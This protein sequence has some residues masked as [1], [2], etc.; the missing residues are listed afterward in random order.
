[1]AHYDSIE[2]FAEARGLKVEKRPNPRTVKPKPSSGSSG[3]SKKSERKSY[4]DESGVIRYEGTDR[5]KES[6]YKKAKS[7]GQKG[8]SGK[9]T[10]RGGSGSGATKEKQPKDKIKVERTSE[11]KKAIQKAKKTGE[12]QL[13]RQGGTVYTIKPDGSFEVRGPSSAAREYVRKQRL[14][15]KIRTG[16]EIVAGDIIP[17]GGTVFQ[18]DS[19][20][21]VKGI[22]EY[23]EQ[24]QEAD[25]P[26]SVPL[27]QENKFLSQREK[28]KNKE[29]SGTISKWEPSIF[30]KAKTEA[31]KAADIRT[32]EQLE[33]AKQGSK[34]AFKTFFDDSYRMQQY[35]LTRQ[36]SKGNIALILGI[37]AGIQ[38]VKF[39]SAAKI[40]GPAIG[41][42]GGF[43]SKVIKLQK[44]GP[45]TKAAGVGI[46]K[47]LQI[48]SSKPV[49]GGVI[50]LR[51][52]ESGVSEFYRSGDI[53]K[54]VL[55]GGLRFTSDAAAY[56]GF[57]MNF[58]KPFTSGQKYGQKKAMQMGITKT[59]IYGKKFKN[60]GTNLIDK[61]PY[62][63]PS[64]KYP[65]TDR[66]IQML[67]GKV[68]KRVAQES[69]TILYKKIN[70]LNLRE[71]EALLSPRS[72]KPKF[73]DISKLRL[74]ATEPNQQKL[75]YDIGMK[76][77]G[78]SISVSKSK[79][80]F[81]KNTQQVNLDVYQ[82]KYPPKS[83][84]VAAK[85]KFKLFAGKKAVQVLQPKTKYGIQ[86][87]PYK[88]KSLPEAKIKF[89]TPTKT[90]FLPT[91]VLAFAAISAQSKGYDDFFKE[92]LESNFK[93]TSELDESKKQDRPFIDVFN[94]GKKFK[95]DV[96]IDQTSDIT[97]TFKNITTSDKKKTF[98]PSP[99]SAPPQ[100]IIPKKPEKPKPP[101]PFKF[102]GFDFGQTS[103]PEK[104]VPGYHAYAKSNNKYTRVTKKAKTYNQAF[105]RGAKV[106]DS[107]LS[108]K[109]KIERANKKV[110]KPFFNNMDESLK[111]KFKE[112]KDNIFQEKRGSAIDTFG[113][114]RGL[115]VAKYKK[116][117]FRL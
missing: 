3:S 69:Q 45:L 60:I 102:P 58:P 76:D 11:A 35:D 108:M 56:T 111:N 16:E 77:F 113:E 89:S 71:Y 6:E 74:A 79:M 106:V 42:V 63:L 43:G 85:T 86:R 112:K 61:K 44:F 101:K 52:A 47:G 17:R 33:Y 51:T 28:Q 83:P 110:K 46:K 117:R 26:A 41:A 12:E 31:Y 2:D 100:T 114:M 38:Y 88:P 78:R 53:K 99:T 55:A 50:S 92:N 8:K 115:T 29:P 107:T 72:Y 9:P 64:R 73:G 5:Y 105:N 116:Q 18:E 96:N 49:V 103:K 15:E 48:S 10:L 66:Q 94:I 91:N 67:P 4:V 25:I 39:A 40:L 70:K 19:K 81:P 80:G 75:F 82:F 36:Q 7:S 22:V 84:Q 30:D 21:Q 54:A 37:E 104:R 93:I 20:K 23:Q 24:R 14:K 1:M 32:V 27:G 34:Q 13:Y 95:Q 57:A 59:N 62:K 90:S 98:L 97:T 87:G 65:V 68:P 109:F